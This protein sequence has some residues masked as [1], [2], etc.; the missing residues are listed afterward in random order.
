M[1]DT[2]KIAPITAEE[3]NRQQAIFWSES[4]L[5]SFHGSKIHSE[6]CGHAPCSAAKRILSYESALTAS[7]AEIERLRLDASHTN[8]GSARADRAD[9]ALEREKNTDE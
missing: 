4:T 8:S 9:C 1:T 6:D 7:E 5:H 2:A 3:R